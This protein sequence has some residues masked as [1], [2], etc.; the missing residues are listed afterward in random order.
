MKVRDGTL[1]RL[2]Y[3]TVPL[4]L[5]AA[6]WALMYVLAAVHASRAAMLA[7]CVPAVGV[8]ALLVWRGA[9]PCVA[10]DSHRSLHQLALAIGAV[11]ALIA[12]VWTSIPL[13]LLA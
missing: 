4:L 6:H 11:L 3:A 8:A 13:L 5:W 10:R 12:I 1:K 7:L 9:R 2:L